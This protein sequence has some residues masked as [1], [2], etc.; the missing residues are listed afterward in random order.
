MREI[1]ISRCSYYPR[2]NGQSYYK[3]VCPY[4]N[5]MVIAYARSISGSGK[6]CDKCKAL[7]TQGFGVFKAK[8]QGEQDE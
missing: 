5:N 1:K 8:K 4:C 7:I 6:R 3:I 2:A